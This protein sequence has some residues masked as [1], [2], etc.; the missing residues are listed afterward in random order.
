VNAGALDA[1]GHSQVDGRPSGL[2]VAAVS[3]RTVPGNIQEVNAQRISTYMV[4]TKTR[5]RKQHKVS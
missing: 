2:D 1:Q 3:A 4:A 5:R